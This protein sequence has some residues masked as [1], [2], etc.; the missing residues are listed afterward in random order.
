MH[1]HKVRLKDIAARTGFGTNT[2][3]LALRGSTRI[4]E[5]TRQVIARTAAELDYVPNHIAKSL[6]SSRSSTVGLILHEI[7]N[8][9]LTS[10]AEKI[11]LALAAQGYG[12][13]FATSNGS[14]EEELRAIEMVR[15]RMVDGLLIYPL[16]HSRLDH[17]KRLRDQGFPVVLLVGVEGSGV[18]VV[19]IDERAGARDATNHLLSLGH[20]RVGGLMTPQYETAEKHLGFSD[21]LREHDRRLD[22]QMIAYCPSHSIEGG[23]EAMGRLMASSSPPTAIFASSDILALGALRWA[24]M[25]GLRVPE[26]L[27]IVGFDDI[28]AA[29]HAV[30]SLSTIRN[31]V[32]EL[33]RLSVLRLMAL[34]DAKGMLPAAE[35]SLLRGDLIARESTAQA[36]SFEV[37]GREERRPHASH[38]GHG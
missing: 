33:A 16:V 32:D 21:A 23:I 11:Q 5:A 24:S 37:K 7:T 38:K 25:N 10:A 9:I 2:V 27:A 13:L 22:E 4:S 17:L 12:V 1:G 19:G 31:D 36:P 20:H 30:R 8:P 6:V 34:I 26:D 3:S 18:D 14:F 35:T 15:S 28:D 29:R